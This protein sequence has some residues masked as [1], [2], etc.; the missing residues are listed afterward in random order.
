MKLKIK[1]SEKEKNIELQDDG[2]NVSVKIDGEVVAR[3]RHD[4]NFEFYGQDSDSKFEGKWN[5]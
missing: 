3:F 5:E 1:S 2:Y 4:G